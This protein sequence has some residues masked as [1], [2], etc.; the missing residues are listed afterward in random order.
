[1]VTREGPVGLA[2]ELRHLAAQLSIQ[3]RCQHSGDTV[4]AIDRDAHR[5]RELD[6]A[7]DALD[8]R[9]EHVRLAAL[10]RSGLELAALNPVLQLLDVVAIQGGAGDHHLQTVVLRRVVTAAPPRPAAPGWGG[11]GA[12]RERPWRE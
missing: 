3:A 9:V 5:P 8:V 12:G 1:M 7:C 4:A 11:A 2:V 10:T 6:V